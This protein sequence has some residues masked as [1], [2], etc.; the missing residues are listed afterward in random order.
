MQ[1]EKAKLCI[2]R[3]G[4]NGNAT[5]SLAYNQSRTLI[6]TNKPMADIASYIIRE[7]QDIGQRIT[8]ADDSSMG[9]D[10]G[11]INFS[12]DPS[13]REEFV[14]LIVQKFNAQRKKQTA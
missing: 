4:L 1:E 10:T 12:V 2:L 8:I 13:E 3:H 11:D 6:I 7:H 9:A 14:R 5:F